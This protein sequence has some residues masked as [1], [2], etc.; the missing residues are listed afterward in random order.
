[1]EPAQRC[2]ILLNFSLRIQPKIIASKPFRDVSNF[3]K[4]S[5]TIRGPHR[6]DLQIWFIRKWLV[7]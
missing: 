2:E 5:H 7:I 4:I 1:M 3:D 6:K